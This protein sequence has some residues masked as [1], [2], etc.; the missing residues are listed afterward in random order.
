MDNNLILSLV[1]VNIINISI[2]IYL[3]ITIYKMYNN[4]STNIE[5]IFNVILKAISDINKH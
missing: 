2:T 4:L 5:T 3:F 1:L